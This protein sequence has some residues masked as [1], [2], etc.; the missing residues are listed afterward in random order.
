[1]TAPHWTMFTLAGARIGRRTGQATA[2]AELG[3]GLSTLGACERGQRQPSVQFVATYSAY[4]GYCLVVI[5]EGV[6]LAEG[7]VGP[8]LRTLRLAAGLDRSEMAS[9]LHLSGPGVNML[10]R[11]GPSVRIGRF[12]EC[13]TACGYRLG[14]RQEPGETP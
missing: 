2:A 6:L 9:R 11:R 1:M 7:D 4:L 8:C 5:G 13:V 12:E 14:L 10:E 3:V